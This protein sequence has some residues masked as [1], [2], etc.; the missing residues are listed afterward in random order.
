MKILNEAEK[1]EALRKVLLDLSKSQD[2]LKDRKSRSD[3]F[4][5]L[6]SIYYNNSSDNFRH[7]YSDIFACLSLIDA[8]SSLGNLD[9]L[10]QNME[11]IKNGYIPSN[12]DENN[13]LIDISKEIIKLYDH[14]NLDIGRINYT[15]RITEKTQSELTNAKILIQNLNNQIAESERINEESTER[16]NQESE[17]LK[18]EVHNGQKKMQNEYITILGIF[19]SIVF[20]F[21]GGM[22]FSSSVLEN[23]HKSSVYRIMA[24]ALILGI[25]LVN[26]TWILIDFLR[27][28]N[29]QRKRKWIGIILVNTI[30]IG[31][32]L[33]VCGSYKYQW[34]DISKSDA[35]QKEDNSSTTDVIE[36]SQ[37]SAD[38]KQKN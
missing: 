25:I 27:D 4:L 10:S 24:V 38:K 12:S 2:I 35:A 6:E 30:L 36:T 31:G 34:F 13:E 14:T 17:N 5:R 19:T 8:D 1:R 9:I 3:F 16:L 33:M 15:K 21:V 26:L 37:N 20:A 29:G 22:A 18:I 23:L 28:I 11:I 32:L 7:F